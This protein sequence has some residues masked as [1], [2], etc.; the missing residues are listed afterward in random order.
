MIQ[1]S[2]YILYKALAKSAQNGLDSVLNAINSN[3]GLELNEY[4][5]IKSQL[6]NSE[7]YAEVGELSCKMKKVQDELIKK[8]A[9]QDRIEDI[10]QRNNKRIEYISAKLEQMGIY[11]EV[12][13][14]KVFASALAS[15]SKNVSEKT[16]NLNPASAGGVTY[17]FFNGE[18]LAFSGDKLD[19]SIEWNGEVL[20]NCDADFIHEI[21]LAFPYSVATIPDEYFMVNS[22]KNNF[23]KECVLFV[24][25]KIKTQSIAKSNEELGDLLKN[26]GRIRNISEFAKELKNNFNVSVKQCIKK[27]APELSDEIDKNLHCNEASEFLPSSKRVAVLANGLAGDS[28]KTEAEESEEVRKEQEK[29]TQKQNAMSREEL[30]ALMLEDDEEEMEQNSDIQEAQDRADD[31]K[32][33]SDDKFEQDKAKDELERELELALS[34]KKNDN[35]ED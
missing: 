18:L 22:I 5:K 29:E 15:E 17:K 11:N 26:C 23:L 7:T 16:L 13:D 20:K 31:E 28:I 4:E 12:V 34:L 32:Q 24:A 27:N 30:L 14:K 21:V 1:D 35:M 3:C 10:V 9:V 2:D 33:L 6:L 25:S 19:L 8:L